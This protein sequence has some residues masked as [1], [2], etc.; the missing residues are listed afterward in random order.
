MSTADP[1]TLSVAEYLHA[2]GDRVP[3]PGGGAA[4]AI[5]LCQAAA[6]AC[7]VLRYTIGKAKFAEFE[8]MNQSR[9][10]DCET[11]VSDA[12]RL[13][14]EDAIVY[15][16]LNALHQQQSDADA[17]AVAT[18]DAI[19]VPHSV[20]VLSAAF[21]AA[22]RGFPGTTSKPLASDVRV[23]AILADAALR[24]ARANVEVNLMGLPEP[25]RSEVRLSLG[26]ESLE[27]TS[28]VTLR[29]IEAAC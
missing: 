20:V 17:L 4:A 2:L 25:R 10:K 15:A 13:A 22:L 29:E 12:L 23:A 14:H 8:S 21:L 9:L 1:A 19:R 26:V 16:K 6:L 5:T 3:A 11:I 18:A 24:S 7:M 28:R 27:E